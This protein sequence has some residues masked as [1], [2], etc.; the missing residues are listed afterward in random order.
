M[1]NIHDVGGGLYN[2]LFSSAQEANNLDTLISLTETKKYTTSRI[3]RAIWY[4]FLGV[5]SSDV[6]E[7]P[8]YTQ[9]LGMDEVGRTI[10][11]EIGK[12]SSLPIVTKPSNVVALSSIGR[13]Q[14]SN[15]QRADSV[16][17][18]CK[19][20]PGKGDASLRFSPYVKK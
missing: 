5:T 12:Q 16:F 4:S 11:K 15:S 18:L 13:R 19:P 6:K 1:T 3:R 7:A 17:E 8:E 20:S 9:V 2:R 14:L 10:L